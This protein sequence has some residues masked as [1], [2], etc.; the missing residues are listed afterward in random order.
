MTTVDVGDVFE[1]VFTTS[2]GATVQ[3]SWYDP[4]STP[5]IELEPIAEDPPGSGRYPNTLQ[6][7]RAGMWT[8]RVTVSGTATAVEEH[9]VYARPIPA[10]PPLAV[11][12]HISEQFGTL[13]P[14]QEGLAKALLRAASKLVRA[15]YPLVDTQIRDGILDAEVVALAVTNMVLRVLRNPRGLRSQSIGPFSYTYDTQ[16]AAGELVVGANEQ[17]ALSPVT[18]AAA[19][20]SAIGMTRIQAGMAPPVRNCGRY[21][22]GW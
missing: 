8:A 2:A 16:L 13:T 19:A 12:G 9:Y 3:R 10:I 6:A 1:L 11:I 18:A 22:G 15:Q 14:A 4:D 21:R 5:A 7:T 17:A 20:V